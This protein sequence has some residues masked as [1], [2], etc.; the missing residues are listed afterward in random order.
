[1]ESNENFITKWEYRTQYEQ[2]N[3]KAVTIDIQ[4]LG[5]QGWEA[6]GVLTGGTIYFKRPCGK[7]KIQEKQK[8]PQYI[9]RN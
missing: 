9:N 7:I 6:F 8:D 5:K 2:V 4:E 1:M 3:N